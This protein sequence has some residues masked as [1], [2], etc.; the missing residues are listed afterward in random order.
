MYRIFLM[1]SFY[2]LLWGSVQASE[3]VADNLVMNEQKIVTVLGQDL[4]KAMGNPISR[5]SLEIVKR[6]RYRA[7]PFQ[8]DEVD[9]HGSV[10][11]AQSKVPLDGAIGILDANDELLFRAIDAGERRTGEELSSGT[12]VAEIEVINPYGETRYAYLVEGSR[13]RSDVAFVRYSK[14]LGLLETDF[15]SITVNRKNALMWDDFRYHSYEDGEESPFDV[16]KIRLIT[17]VVLKFA[18]VEFNNK[19][20]VAK[21][22]AEKIGP[23]R[24]TSEFKLSIKFLKLPVLSGRIQAHYLPNSFNYDV[25]ANIPT[26]RRKFIRDPKVSISFDGNDLAGAN[27]FT[28]NQKEGE[29]GL[30]DGRISMDEIALMDNMYG[31][32]SNWIMVKT[33]RNFDWVSSLK[34]KSDEL[35]TPLGFFLED[36]FEKKDKPERFRGQSPNVGYELMDLPKRGDVQLNF[37]VYLGDGSDKVSPATVAETVVA[38][39]KVSTVEI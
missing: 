16:L 4:V 6:G 3:Q 37:S 35:S 36:D 18:K 32:G 19:N 31:K 21:P 22:V 10:F 12:V 26:F 30:V 33:H 39:V 28:V 7:I 29:G 2:C 25:R 5:Y 11:F 24:A 38:P 27:I 34:F 15:Y 20:F 17:G 13:L 23:I 8:F 1:I 9:I 14:D